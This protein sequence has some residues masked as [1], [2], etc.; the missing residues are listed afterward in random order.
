MIDVALTISPIGS[1]AAG[2]YG[3]SVIARDI[4][5]ERRRRRAREF[6]IDAT[7]DLDASLDPTETARNIVAK[8]VPELAEVC[9]ID[10]IREDGRIG[11]SVAASAIPG[12]AERLEALR[13]E[14]PLDPDGDA[15]R[16]PGPAR[17]PADDLPRPGRPR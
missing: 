14:A 5:E 8:A 12:A 10:F 11:D 4:T 2:L 13:R 1:Q 17:R 9:I 15:S 3:A 7:R 6:L 16:R